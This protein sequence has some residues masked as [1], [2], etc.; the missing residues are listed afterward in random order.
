[1]LLNIEKSGEYDEEYSKEWLVNTD[2]DVQLDPNVRIL[3]FFFSER[4]TQGQPAHT[5]SL[6][7]IYN[8]AYIVTLDQVNQVSAQESEIRFCKI[9]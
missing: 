8:P 3:L 4:V 2:P 1:M 6:L 7:L 9:H 5:W